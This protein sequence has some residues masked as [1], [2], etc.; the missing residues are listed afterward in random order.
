[1]WSNNYFQGSL[2]I[3]VK[4][5][6]EEVIWKDIKNKV[7]IFVTILFSCLPREVKYE[8]WPLFREIST[9]SLHLQ[10]NQFEVKY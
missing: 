7:Y 5:P 2:L 4:N 10:P 9:H 1:M 3:L 8:V 6:H